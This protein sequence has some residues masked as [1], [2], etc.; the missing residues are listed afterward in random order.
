MTRSTSLAHLLTVALAIGVLAVSAQDVGAQRLPDDYPVVDRDFSSRLRHPAGGRP[1]IGVFTRDRSYPS[2]GSRVRVD[3]LPSYRSRGVGTRYRHR[4]F[5]HAVPSFQYFNQQQRNYTY[6]PNTYPG[7]D[8]VRPGEIIPP[9]YYY[10]NP[11]YYRYYR[12]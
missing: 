9:A 2:F 8:N 3:E 4:F 12:Y 6:T 10:Y 7:L 1:G 5:D 11:R